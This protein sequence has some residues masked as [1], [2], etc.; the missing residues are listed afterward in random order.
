[1]RLLDGADSGPLLSSSTGLGDSRRMAV[2]GTFYVLAY[3][4]IS[5]AAARI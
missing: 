5:R 4:R 1:M 3:G 2:P